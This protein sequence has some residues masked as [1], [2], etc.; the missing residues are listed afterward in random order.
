M[1]GLENIVIVELVCHQPKLS[2]FVVNKKQSIVF[3]LVNRSTFIIG[4]NLLEYW[5]RIGSYCQW[6]RAN[7]GSFII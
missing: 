2:L 7:V 3:S 4:S 1:N 5:A 6:G